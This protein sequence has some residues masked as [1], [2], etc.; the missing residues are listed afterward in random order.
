MSEPLPVP[1]E[2]PADYQDI[3][4]TQQAVQDAFLAVPSVVG[5]AL[6]HKLVGGQD[7]GVSA[8]VVLVEEKVAE[9][10]LPNAQIVPPAIGGTPI[11]VQAVGK[12]RAGPEPLAASRAVSLTRRTR[13]MTGGM[14]VGHHAITAGT[15]AT[16]CYRDS[17]FPGMPG[18]YYILSNNHVL[19]NSNDAQEGD[20]ILQPGPFDGGTLENDQ[21]G[22]LAK[23]V[24]IKFLDGSDPAPTNEVDAAIAE[25]DLMDIDRSIHWMGELRSIALTPEV[26]LLL[27]KCGRTTGFTTG[28]IVNINATVDVN[29][30]K[31]RIA[32][33]V[34][35]LVTTNMSAPGDSGSLVADLHGNA[36]GLLFAGSN[37]ATIVNPITTVQRLLGVKVV[38]G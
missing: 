36:V 14:S 32:R 1:P 4:R 31:G 18:R 2:V 37:V 13:P 25:V 19:A 28:R 10:E 7:T 12:L 3:A 8:I 27:C 26:G 16:G 30:G 34:N 6:G 22:R 21:I 11:D 29:Y 15:A 9:R 17:P 35:Q 33:F 38:D 24:P 5:V 20:A 23:F